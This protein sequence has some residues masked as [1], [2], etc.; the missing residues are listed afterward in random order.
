MYNVHYCTANVAELK[1]KDKPGFPRNMIINI[2]SMALNTGLPVLATL[3]LADNLLS[4]IPFMAI[5]NLNALKMLGENILI[6]RS[7]TLFVFEI[8]TNSIIFYYF[9]RF[10]DYKVKK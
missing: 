8:K 7:I 9:A 3:N 4:K 6:Y 10:L 2:H 5:E 1:I